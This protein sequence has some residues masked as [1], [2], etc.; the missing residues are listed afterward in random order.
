M[1]GDHIYGLMGLLATCGLAGK[2][3]RIDIYGPSEL[4]EYLQ[5]CSQHSHTRFPYPVEVHTVKRG[6][7]FEDDE[8][9][10]SCN[11]LKHR[12][13]AFGYRVM[14]KDRPGHF[15]VEKA[16]ALGIPAGPLYGKLKRG[17]SITL[18]A[19]RVING[20]ELC[21]PKERGRRIVYCTDTIYCDT[22]VELA[23]DADVLIHEATFAQADEELARQSWHSTTVMAA[24]VASAARVRRLMIT[25]FSPRYTPGNAIE[26]DDLLR[27]A[28]AIFPNTEMAR[29]FLTIEVPRRKPAE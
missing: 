15:D 11:P 8:Y 26:P 10:V 17:E 21:G 3:Q 25:H 13:S 2:P 4:D 7:I 9:V 28:R 5:A 14:E 27:E 18:P 23:Q 12:V 29:D 1:H 20:A 16:A 6:V 19:G 22:A 24:Q